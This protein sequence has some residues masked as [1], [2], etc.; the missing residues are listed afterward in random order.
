MLIRIGGNLKPIGNVLNWI[1]LAIFPNHCFGSAFLDMYSNYEAIDTCTNVYN[2]T[3]TCLL[4]SGPCCKGYGQLLHVNT[5]RTVHPLASC[6]KRYRQLLQL[7]FFYNLTVTY[8]HLPCYK[9]TISYC[10]L[11]PYSHVSP[12]AAY[13]DAISCCNDVTV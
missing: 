2:Y 13:K 9:D 3:F 11:K 4:E 5:S 10:F 12:F 1:F 7:F 8:L 6:F